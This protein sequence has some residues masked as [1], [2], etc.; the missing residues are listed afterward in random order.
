MLR[1]DRAVKWLLA[2]RGPVERRLILES[3]AV[4]F[5]VNF[6]GP[7]ILYCEGITFKFPFLVYLASG[8]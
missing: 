4:I 6:A 7:Y 2:L 1:D 3:E 5:G 8:I